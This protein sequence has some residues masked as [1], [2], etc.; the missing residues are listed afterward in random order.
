M[1]GVKLT[2]KISS[3]KRGVDVLVTVSAGHSA[4]L[5]YVIMQMDPTRVFMSIRSSTSLPTQ[6]SF[7]E[8]VH[9]FIGLI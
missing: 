3:V 2:A 8:V 1:E 9:P 4:S 7:T 6:R 5:C